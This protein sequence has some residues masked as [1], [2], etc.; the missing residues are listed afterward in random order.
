MS[1]P[2]DKIR[3][4]GIIAHIDAGKTTVTERILYYTGKEHRIGEV[5]EGTATM[6]YLQEEQE[7]GITIT[8]A[9]TTCLWRDCQINLIDTPGHVDFTAEVERSLR[10]L[11]GA[12]GVFCAVAGVEAQSETVW[13]QA[14]VYHVPRLAFVNKM[15]RIGANFFRVVEQIKKRLKANPVVLL[16]PIG[17]EKEFRGVIDLVRME[18]IHYDDESQGARFHRVPIPPELEETAREHR[19]ILEEQL[20]ETD[21][22]LTEKF[23][24][25][26]KIE[27]EDLVRGIR[28]ATISGKIVPVFCGSALKNKG[29]QRL[30]DGVTA[31]LPSP[32]EVPPARG[33]DPEDVDRI[34]DVPSD[35][36]GHLVAM[37]FKT[38]GDRHGD[39]TF[40]RVYSGT[41]KAGTQVY[42]PRTRKVERISRIFLMHAA[43]RQ[44]IDQAEAGSICA[45]TGLKQS[46]TGDT[47]CEKA[48][49]V[50]LESMHFPET[51]I[52]M[53]IEPK[54]TADRDRLAEALAQLAKEDPTFRCTVQEETGQLLIYGMGELHLEIIRHR[55]LNDFKVAVS[56]GKPRVAFKQAV[57]GTLVGE[58]RFVKQTG[59][60]GQYGHVKLRVEPWPEENFAFVDQTQGG[61]IPKE[62]MGAVKEGA[63]AA[64][65]AGYE[66]GYPVINAK[67]TVLDGS[68]H[69]VDSSDI[70][71]QQAAFLA[72]EDAFA[73]GGVVLLEPYMKLQVRTPAEF[74]SNVIGDLNARRASIDEIDT[75]EEPNEITVSVPLS[76]VFGYASVVRSLSQGRAA[77]AMEPLEYRPVPPQLRD[78]LVG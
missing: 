6:D 9:A 14:N 35:A 7:R 67:V 57:E 13:R 77:F 45:V 33:H 17:A 55:L 52:S 16:M 19:A 2:I 47:L 24:M 18:A 61:V 65:D 5:H 20:A 32:S 44:P 46:V 28:A 31:F 54:T 36:T 30:L 51:V 74:L 1:H 10:V 63:K 59:G 23:L 68:F 60:H 15:D 3:N 71:F 50:A 72:V 42:N 41:L 26:E 53:A 38:I 29:V 27:T 25:E 62:F 40:V 22:V 56:V 12:I 69:E 78:K 43:A 4:I 66:L 49:I 64:C 34:I 58:A 37:C 76:E 70:A 8:S 21:D 73:R 75:A 39:L 48:W 11:D